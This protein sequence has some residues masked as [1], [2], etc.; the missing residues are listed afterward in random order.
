MPSFRYKARDNQ[1]RL[2][3]GDLVSVNQLS[4]IQKLQDKGLTIVGLN[5]IDENK[6]KAPEFKMFRSSRESISID[7]LVLLTRQLYALNKAGVPIVRALSGLSESSDHTYL[8]HVLS[9]A[10]EAVISGGDLATAFRQFPD[11]F[12]QIF[13][14]MVHVGES[15]GRLDLAFNKLTHH[16][17]LERETKKRIK[18]AI[19]YPTFVISAMAIA[20]VIINIF[21]IP[22]FANVFSKLGENLPFATQ[23]LIMTSNLM[24]NYWWLMLLTT[25]GVYLF[26]KHYISSSSGQYWWDKKKMEIPL[27]GS[28]FKRI[29][30]SRFS[31]TFSMM[32]SAGVPILKALSITS[33]AVGNRYIASGIDQMRKGVERGETLTS[34]A[35]E[36]GFFTPLVIQML[37]VGEET[38]SVDDL[39]NDVADF[40]EEEIDYDLKTLSDSIE[41]ILLAFLGILVLILALGV[42]LPMW[43]LSNAMSR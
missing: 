7:Q 39:L 29:A 3:T 34:S 26:I 8:K 6:N 24:I 9:Q 22:N 43:D 12:S 27:L 28:L 41:P 10:S 33:S 38:G 18:T 13:I 5:E 40:Y 37:A 2:L 23:L 19:R 21:V 4:V 15:T 17:E 42:F 1:G 20:M 25:G 35:S 11:V 36:T 14:S 30:L 32:L 16:L 31:R